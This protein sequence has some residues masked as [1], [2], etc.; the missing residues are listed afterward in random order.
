MEKERKSRQVAIDGNS[1]DENEEKTKR[2][3]DI[4]S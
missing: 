1:L 2:S 4:P 3:I